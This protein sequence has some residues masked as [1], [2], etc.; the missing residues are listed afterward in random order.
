MSEEKPYMYMRSG[1]KGGLYFFSPKGGIIY[2]MNR[3]HVVDLMNGVR[4]FVCINRKRADE[5]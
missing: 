3:E 2:F 4:D 5:K 1:K